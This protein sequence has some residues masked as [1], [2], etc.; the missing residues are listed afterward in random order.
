MWTLAQ[1]YILILGPKYGCGKASCKP[2]CECNRF[3][4]F[5]NLVFQQYNQDEK[6]ILNPLPKGGIDT[7]LG[8]ERLT[9]ILQ[10]VQS[11]FETDLIKPI[12]NE[13]SLITG[14]Q[15]GKNKDFDVHLRI[16]ADHIRAITFF[17]IRWCSTIK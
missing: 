16:I 8:L 10:G 9:A 11:N 14:V 13:I 5:W 4:E 7:G 6:G 2:G 12:I 17:N 1:K 15:Y 3:E